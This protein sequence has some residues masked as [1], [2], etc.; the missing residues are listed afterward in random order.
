MLHGSARFSAL[1]RFTGT[2][3]VL[4]ASNTR[5]TLRFKA[6][7]CITTSH[8]LF[9]E[10]FFERHVEGKIFDSVV[11]P[12]LPPSSE[13]INIIP[14]C[15]EPPSGRMQI[16][17]V[18]F[19]IQGHAFTP[20]CLLADHLFMQREYESKFVAVLGGRFLE[21]Y[22]IIVKSGSDYRPILRIPTQGLHSLQR[23]ILSV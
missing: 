1:P 23:W 4:P 17:R 8:C 20:K 22:S 3:L 6:V 16:A 18:P 19:S 2:E 14:L 5:K 7:I 9:L 11:Y 13:P 12:K 21:A 10:S 15:G